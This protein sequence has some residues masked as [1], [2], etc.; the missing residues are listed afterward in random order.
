MEHRERAAWIVAFAIPGVALIAWGILTLRLDT[1]KPVRAPELTRPLDP[2]AAPAPRIH[3]TRGSTAPTVQPVKA[4]S[5][6]GGR[7]PDALRIPPDDGTTV[8]DP[9]GANLASPCPQETA[10]DLALLYARWHTEPMDAQ[11][12]ERMQEYLEDELQQ[13]AIEP[14]AYHVR[15]TVS[16]C[17]A[18]FR[19]HEVAELHRMHSVSVPDGRDIRTTFPQPVSKDL[20]DLSVYMAKEG[21]ELQ[22]LATIRE[23]ESPLP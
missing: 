11:E 17:R 9:A 3:Q 2:P 1:P 5:G 19:F 21:T 15:C 14:V 16:L 12:T 22:A 18:R 4:S 7:L 23:P 8:G 20:V 10:D 13:H 6:G